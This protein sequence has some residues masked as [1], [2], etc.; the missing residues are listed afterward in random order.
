MAQLGRVQKVAGFLTLPAILVGFTMGGWR[1]ALTGA[2]CVTAVGSTVAILRA[3][4]GTGMETVTP[5]MAS[6]QRKTAIAAGVL[7]LLATFYGGWSMGWLYGVIGYIVA[8]GAGALLF[9]RRGVATHHRTP[10]PE[11]IEDFFGDSERLT[12]AYLDSF[13]PK[14]PPLLPLSSL[15]TSLDEMKS[16]LLRTVLHRKVSGQLTPDL[17]SGFRDFY[18]NL[19]RFVDDA[20][21]AHSATIIQGDDLLNSGEVPTPDQIRALARAFVDAGNADALGHD[22]E[23][24]FAL[25]HEFDERWAHIATHAIMPSM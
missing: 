5:E 9:A 1:G 6:N 14:T 3:E 22:T 4:S 19:S 8:A 20:R 21:A 24:R 23:A 16:A 18:G 13:T 12:D 11:D 15:P 17:L 7:V 2:V 25:M 10:T